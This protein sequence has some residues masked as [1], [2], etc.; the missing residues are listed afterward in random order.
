MKLLSPQRHSLPGFIDTSLERCRRLL[1]KPGVDR[2]PI[3]LWFHVC[4]S[5]CFKPTRFHGEISPR[6]GTDLYFTEIYKRRILTY[7]FHLFYLKGACM[8]RCYVCLRSTFFITRFNFF[9]CL[10]NTVVTFVA[11]VNNF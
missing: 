9:P 3:I 1:S 11:V 2:L 4:P 8:M 10:H 7:R 5:T 6:F